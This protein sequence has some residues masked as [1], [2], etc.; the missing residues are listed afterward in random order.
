MLA[1]GEA[2]VV[3]QQGR[4]LSQVHRVQ[5]TAAVE[6]LQDPAAIVLGHERE[7]LGLALLDRQGLARHPRMLD[8]PQVVIVDLRV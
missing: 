4:D 7:C 8:R 6:L 1:C 2:L 5:R 3:R